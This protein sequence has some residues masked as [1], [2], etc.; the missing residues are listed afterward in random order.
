VNA[1]VNGGILHGEQRVDPPEERLNPRSYYHREG[2]LGQIIE[3]IRKRK[4]HPEIAGIGLGAGTLAAYG[5]QNNSI[6]F[7]ELNPNVERLARNP[8]YFTYVDDCLRRWCNLKVELGD[9]RLGMLKTQ[10]TFDLIVVDAFSSDAI[11]VHLLTTEALYTY[12]EKLN[13]G[14][15]IA[16]HISNRYVNLEPVI[17]NL[18][19]EYGLGYGVRSDDDDEAIGKGASTWVI[20]ARENGAFDTITADDRWRGLED[21]DGIGLW[22]DDYANVTRAFTWF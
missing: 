22:A 15:V 8:K 16:F 11:P 17:L 14:G 1:L 13:E 20:V 3:V 21:K 12:L 18:A 19:K 10:E 2:P 7:F 6:T 5:E 9:G 4:E